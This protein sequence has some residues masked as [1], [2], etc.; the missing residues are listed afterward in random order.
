ML[1]TYLNIRKLIIN[2]I[3]NIIKYKEVKIQFRTNSIYKY[4]NNFLF[5]IV[6]DHRWYDIR[7]THEQALA[8]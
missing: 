5:T 1:K 6:I 2:L 7:A 3:F 8:L 4:I